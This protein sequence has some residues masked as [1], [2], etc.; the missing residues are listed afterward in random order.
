MSYKDVKENFVSGHT[1]TSLSEIALV[2]SSAPLGLL[3]RNELQS[4]TQI[5][6][7]WLVCHYTINIRQGCVML[8]SGGNSR[9]VRTTCEL[10]STSG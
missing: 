1:G 6:G 5:K 4:F 2:V 3:L 9:V 8:R 10:V 7:H